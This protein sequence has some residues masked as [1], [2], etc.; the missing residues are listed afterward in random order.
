[1][2]KGLIL[3]HI[4]SGRYSIRLLSDRKKADKSLARID[5]WIAMNS[6]RIVAALAAGDP[7]HKVAGLKL[8]L[9]SLI[10]QKEYLNR[11]PPD[12]ETTAYCADA[13][14]DLT[15]E[16]GTIEIN[17]NADGVINI[18]PGYGDSARYSA[19]RDGVTQHIMAMTPEQAFYNMAMEP[20]WQRWRPLHMTG[21]ITAIAPDNK[22]CHVTLEVATSRFQGLPLN[23][24]FT[25]TSIPFQ[26]M[27]CDGDAFIVGDRVIV[28]FMNQDPTQGT[29][30][31]FAESPRPCGHPAVILT[32][33]QGW[34]IVWDIETDD[35]ATDAF[36]IGEDDQRYVV[37]KEQYP[38]KD[39]D[40]SDFEAERIGITMSPDYFATT[41]SGFWTYRETPPSLYAGEYLAS[42][43]KIR[44]GDY[45]YPAISVYENRPWMFTKIK[46]I[47]PVTQIITWED[48]SKLVGIDIIFISPW[49]PMYYLW[50]RY[51]GGS[52][53]TNPTYP[54]YL[55]YWWYEYMSEENPTKELPS[56]PD[57]RGVDGSR[58]AVYAEYNHL[59]TYLSW[60]WKSTV[61]QPTFRTEYKI[62][63][64]GSSV[65]ISGRSNPLA[66]FNDPEQ[67]GSA[68]YPYRRTRDSSIE[69][70][71]HTEDN[72]P[73]ERMMAFVSDRHCVQ[74]YPQMFWEPGPAVAHCSKR[75]AP[76][77][78]PANSASGKLTDALRMLQDKDA[79]NLT[80]N[81][82]GIPHEPGLPP[83]YLNMLDA[84]YDGDKVHRQ[85]AITV[86]LLSAPRVRIPGGN[87]MTDA[88]NA[89]RN[90]PDGDPLLVPHT[91]DYN[92]MKAAQ[93]KVN[94]FV[95][96]GVCQ[97]EEPNGEQPSQ[98][99]NIAIGFT[100]STD[101]EMCD[102]WMSSPHHKATLLHPDT[103]IVG[104]ASA[105][106]PPELEVI[107]RGPAFYDPD[108]GGYTQE[109]T[110]IEIP[111]EYRGT[112]KCYVA[113]Y[114]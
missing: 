50:K 17:G 65:R 73:C 92:L 95:E 19:S 69:G 37:K 16:V 106:Y 14:E 63:T 52:A 15:G 33:E 1:M 44:V 94:F 91:P 2:G 7:D 31:G 96:N 3:N 30:V 75:P 110:Y 70:D 4:K 114:L 107:T 35:Y 98:F 66:E 42:D 93:D 57:G 67:T 100:S 101:Q 72:P 45:G 46:S 10:K 82:L 38:I 109:K 12:E 51:H 13:T 36:L 62:A 20:G 21:L 103:T 54:V 90:G 5:G 113:K 112:I 55:D 18:Q 32:N 8:S 87:S 34:S 24:S 41:F 29:V 74:I 47:D 88:L 53:P 111:E 11:I 81:T 27:D 84:Y 105:V 108:T 78:V 77:S 102:A 48:P 89:T 76:D 28:R 71:A 26:Y 59:Y 23:Q 83:F 64:S 80:E 25:L 43:A 99:E 49:R 22:S 104:V 9:A 85:C 40:W 39:A 56:E 86:T 97:H 79:C 58:W 68:N 61:G 60:E 6:E